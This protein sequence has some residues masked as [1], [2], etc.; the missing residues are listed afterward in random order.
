MLLL[1]YW[2]ARR[3]YRRLLFWLG[4]VTF[5]SLVATLLGIQVDQKAAPLLAQESYDW[6]GWYLILFPV[7]YAT[8]W[9]MLATLLAEAL[10]SEMLRRSDAGGEQDKKSGSFAGGVPLEG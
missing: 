1:P 6:T 7:S 9:L 3:R 8:S 5:F 10:R 4:F 2:F